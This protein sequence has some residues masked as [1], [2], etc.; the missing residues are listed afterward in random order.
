M[1]ST[2]L[3]IMAGAVVVSAAALV[4]QAVM[5]YGTFRAASTIRDRVVELLPKLEGLVDAARVAV[6]ESRAGVAEVRAKSNQIL[7]LTHKQL[8]Q[9]ESFLA[10]A[11]ERTRRQLSHAE[12]VIDDT[13]DRVEETVALVHKGILKPVRGAGAVIAG[14]RTMIQVLMRGNRPS[15]DRATADEEMFI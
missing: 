15:P 11:G 5:L 14:L 8:Q 2:L 9:L 12:A 13:L 10:E 3:M 6:D 1:D 7:E 4:F